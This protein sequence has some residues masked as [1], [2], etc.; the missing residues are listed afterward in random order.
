ME[1]AFYYSALAIFFLTALSDDLFSQ[2]KW[3]VGFRIIPQSPSLRY[4]TPSPISDFLKLTPYYS[5]LRMAQGIGVVYHLHRRWSVAADIIYSMQG[6][7]YKE[8]KTNLNYFKIPVT[9]GYNA[10]NSRKLVFNMQTGI[11]VNFLASAKLKYQDGQVEDI[12]KYLSKV[13]LGVPF[14]IGWKFKLSK[15]YLMNTQVYA[16]TDFTSISKTDQSFKV[17]NYILPGIRFSVDQPLR[18]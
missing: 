18:K 3:E 13:S 9:I 6:G 5:R 1:K 16:N 2:P 17:N 4:K 10:R 11:D 8:R 14:S 7:G 15:S 12:G